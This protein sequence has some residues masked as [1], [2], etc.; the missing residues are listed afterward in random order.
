MK[1]FF[2]LVLMS[3]S[4]A[5]MMGAANRENGRDAH[6]LG[7]DHFPSGYRRHPRSHKLAKNSKTASWSRSMPGG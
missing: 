3:A 4:M 6:C 7:G 1:M 2:G 5:I